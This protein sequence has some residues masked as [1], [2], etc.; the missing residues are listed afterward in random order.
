[1]RAIRWLRRMLV[2]Y[3]GR[4]QR[5][6]ALAPPARPPPVTPAPAPKTRVAGPCLAAF[7]SEMYAMAS[8]NAWEN[9]G[10]WAWLVPI[11][12]QQPAVDPPRDSAQDVTPVPPAPAVE[13]ESRACGQRHREART[14]RVVSPHVRK[15]VK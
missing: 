9:D 8:G 1:M 14:T 12:H 5:V 7:D 3:L 13:T 6:M 15:R 4:T 11:G 2:A 10:D